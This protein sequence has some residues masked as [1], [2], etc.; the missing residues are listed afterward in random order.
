MKT[1]SSKAN[2]KRAAKNAGMDLNIIDITERQGYWVIEQAAQPE[3]LPEP[4]AEIILPFLVKVEEICGYNPQA[5]LGYKKAAKAV[6]KES[7]INNP[8]KTVWRIADEMWGQPRKT[9]I[10]ACVEAGIAYNTARTQYQAF[11]QIKKLEGKN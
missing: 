3:L 1:Y 2:A 8:V 5:L 9:I 7:S 11:Y 4:P 6:L 10:A